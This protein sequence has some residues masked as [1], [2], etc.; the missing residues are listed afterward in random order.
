PNLRYILLLA[1][2][3]VGVVWAG[4]TWKSEY[5]LAKQAHSHEMIVGNSGLEAEVV[6][7][8][9][10]EANS[11]EE[12]ILPTQESTTSW[13]SIF[14]RGA[15]TTKV[16]PYLPLITLGWY[17]GVLIMSM[18]TLLGFF[19]LY[20]LKTRDVMLPD[21]KWKAVF[22]EMTAKMGVFKNVQFLLTEKLQEPVTFYLLKPVVLVPLSLCTGMNPKQVEVLVLHELAHIRRNDF[23]VN[24][25]QS[26]I[27]ILFFFHPAVWWISGKIREEREHGCDDMV[28]KVQK[29]PMVYAEALTKLKITFRP[30]KTR[31]AMA[32]KSKT[33]AFSQRIFRL[34][35][36]Y[37]QRPQFVKG[38]L[39]ALLLLM[40]LVFQAFR[41]PGPQVDIHITSHDHEKP[42][43]E[44]V[45]IVPEPDSEPAPEATAGSHIDVFSDTDEGSHIDIFPEENSLAT[46]N[47]EDEPK[48]EALAKFVDADEDPSIDM[49]VDA[50]HNNMISVAKYLVEQG[51]D[52]N[53][54]GHEGYTPLGEAAHHDRAEMI[55][56]LLSNGAKLEMKDE[57]GRTALVI[58]ARNCAS[59][60]A[61]F[62]LEKGADVNAVDNKGNSV[63]MY[64]AH[65]G[66]YS[67]VKFLL[68]AG[69]DKDLESKK[70]VTALSTAMRNGHEEVVLLLL[71]KE[72][73]QSEKEDRLPR[74]KKRG[75]SQGSNS[76]QGSAETYGIAEYSEWTPPREKLIENSKPIGELPED[77]KGSLDI[78]ANGTYSVSF[79][80][81]EQKMKTSLTIESLE[82]ETLKTIFSGTLGKGTNTLSW[83][84]SKFPNK[85]YWMVI[86]VE[87]EEIRQKIGR[88]TT[89]DWRNISAFREN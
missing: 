64:A 24:L 55:D 54:V 47:A 6:D 45:A 87:G 85:T 36:Q 23:F 16:G 48:P 13:M 9:S 75:N 51:V 50:I 56:F 29:D 21:A 77:L 22:E 44:A 82:G 80:K 49:L 26:V 20:R 4:Q 43:T 69:A 52:V 30:Q 35:G 10:L 14:D 7:A 60:T 88:N 34:F 83:S 27:E 62:L 18:Y 73:D 67:L 1:S 17:I 5:Q 25:I 68:D 28:L 46:P 40:T 57:E 53:Q 71:G 15:L 42:V 86:E 38:S 66:N 70:G 79:S 89:S 61:N 11:G 78:S 65:M 72:T 39:I 59:E 33:S 31:L 2:L 58:A 19:Y 81:I 41:F 74:R 3:G 32:A 37:D 84:M 12:A 63:L 8:P 76:I